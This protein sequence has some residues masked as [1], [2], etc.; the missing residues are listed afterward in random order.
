MRAE[1]LFQRPVRKRTIRSSF[2]AER[3]RLM[4]GRGLSAKAPAHQASLSAGSGALLR[5]RSEAFSASHCPWA[6]VTIGTRRQNGHFLRLDVF[7]HPLTSATVAT[8]G[9]GPN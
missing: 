5:M 9:V 7:T 1:H 3:R 2:P 6:S 4:D 8:S